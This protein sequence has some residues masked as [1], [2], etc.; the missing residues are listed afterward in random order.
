MGESKVKAYIQNNKEAWE[1]SFEASKIGF[2]SKD[3]DRL[4]NEVFP[5][6]H[7]DL[8][9][10]MSE[11]NLEGKHIGQFC[12]NNGRELLSIIKGTGAQSGVGFDIAENIINQ[13]KSH[14][15]ECKIPCE[16]VNCNILDI[17]EK[18]GEQFDAIFVL[19]G[20]LCWFEDLGE[21]FE[22]VSKCLKKDGY[23]FIQEGHPCTNM[24]AVNGEE[25]YDPGNKM[26]IAWSYFKEEP[27]V[28]DWGIGY[29]VGD[30]IKS[31][32]F[33]SFAHKMSDI[34]NGIIQSGLKIKLLEEYDYD[35]TG[36][37]KVISG[38]GY[39]LSYILVAER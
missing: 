23:L 30:T 34:I 28:D 19:I 22:K 33:T 32:P 20:T 35:V 11:Y 36:E 27:F 38:K 1:E 9:K 21:F 13:A 4:Q 12:C 24:L 17:E 26:K 3:C 29:M 18:Y 39:P 37:F 2:G 14:A 15:K 5:F 16:F 7:K 6:I 8:K 10:I 25:A 31:K